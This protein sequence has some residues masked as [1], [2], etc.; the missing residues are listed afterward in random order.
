MFLRTPDVGERKNCPFPL[1]IL[2]KKKKKKKKKLARVLPFLLLL[3]D[4]IWKQSP[5]TTHTYYWAWMTKDL[6]TLLLIMNF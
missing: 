3:R 1:Y 6:A 2:Q 5:E 4:S